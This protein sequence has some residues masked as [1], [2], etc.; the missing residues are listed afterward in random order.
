[1]NLPHIITQ[2]EWNHV[3][4]TITELRTSNLALIQVVNDLVTKVHELRAELAAAGNATELDNL[5][6]EIDAATAAGQA[7][8]Q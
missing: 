7:G 5:K 4:A 8:L 1:M 3:M 6:Q 2:K